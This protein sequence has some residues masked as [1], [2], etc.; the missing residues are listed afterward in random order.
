MDLLCEY[1]FIWIKTEGAFHK[2]PNIH[3]YNIWQVI[4]G[5]SLLLFLL[6]LLLLLLLSPHHCMIVICTG[7]TTLNL[8]RRPVF[9][10]DTPSHRQ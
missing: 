5:L 6:L 8:A 4:V 3:I 2:H 9:H 10:P 7:F 1:G